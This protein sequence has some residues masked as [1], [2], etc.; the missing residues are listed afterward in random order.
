MLPTTATK[1]INYNQNDI[2]ISGNLD[3]LNGIMS[4]NLLVSSDLYISPMFDPSFYSPSQDQ[5]YPKNM[6]ET[7][8]NSTFDP[9]VDLK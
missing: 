8:I 5:T 9:S 1:Y 6:Y 2:N 3:N 7:N 4:K